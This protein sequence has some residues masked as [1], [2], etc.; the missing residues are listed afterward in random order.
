M[1]APGNLTDAEPTDSEGH[2]KSS[3]DIISRLPV[4]SSLGPSVQAD[5]AKKLVRKTVALGE[6]VFRVGDPPGDF[7]LIESGRVRAVSE[8]TSGD[9]VVLV[10]LGPDEYFGELS[11]LTDA[12]RSV[13]IRAAEETR[14]LVLPGD[15][16]R[17]VAT[18]NP[19]VRQA[20]ACRMSLYNLRLFLRTC[21]VFSTMPARLMNS[22]MDKI[23]FRE[24][25]KGET[26]IREGD[27]GKSFFTIDRGTFEVFRG[28]KLVNALG[29]G[30]SFGEVSLI[31]LLPRSATVKASSDGSLVVV[32]ADLCERIIKEAPEFDERLKRSMQTYAL[33]DETPTAETPGSARPPADPGDDEESVPDIVNPETAKEKEAREAKGARPGPFARFP[34]L[35]QQDETDCAAACLGMVAKYHGK[36]MSLSRLRDIV[37]VTTE[38]AS[39][40]SLAHGA[41]SIGFNARAMRT[42]MAK[43]SSLSLPAI[44]HWNGNHYV[45]LWNIR[46]SKA[47]IGDPAIGRKS[48]SLTEFE[49]SWTGYV[50]ELRAT[51][52]LKEIKPARTSLE[53]FVPLLSEHRLIIFEV[54]LCSFLLDLFGL[55]QPLFTQ[56]VV[57]KVFVHHSRNLLNAMLVGM[58]CVSVLQAFSSALRRY[59]IVYVSSKIDVALITN[60]LRHLMRLPVKYFDVR[61]VGDVIARVDEN[62]SITQTFVGVVP[63]AILDL[64]MAAIYIVMM[65]FYSVKL[66]LIV[67][68]TVIPFA[69]LTLGFTP[70]IRANRREMFAR[71]AASSSFL[72]ENI[73]GIHTVKSLAIETP[74]R[75]KWENLFHRVLSEMRKGAHIDIWQE[76]LARFLSTMTT[77]VLFWYGATLVLGGSLTLGQLFAFNVL[78]GNVM[79]PM[80]GLVGL[81]DQIQALRISLDR[82]NDV[83]DSEAEEDPRRTPI[84]VP[85]IRGEIRFE[86]VTF[87]YGER[88]EKPILNRFNLEIAA[89]STVALV[90]RSGSGKTTLSRMILRFYDPQQGRVFVDGHD[91][92][93]IGLPSLRRQIGVV[94]QDVVLFAGSIRDNISPGSQEIPMT[95]IIEAAQMAGA[96]E[97][98]SAF[99]LGYDTPVGERG[100]TLSGGQRQRISIARAILGDPSILIL[101][102]ATSALDTE[103][104]RAIQRNI[105]NISKGRTTIII[106]HR[107]STVQRADT[108]VVLDQGGV[109]EAGNHKE[110]VARGGL[111]AHL[112]RQQLGS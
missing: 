44:C 19:Q 51:D 95:R 92:R 4:F 75:W 45:V 33:L 82:L 42:S 50:M 10:T 87:S 105:E 48:V 84:I 80:L 64:M 57:D 55:A 37:N 46:G 74:M 16:F 101:D 76:T 14:L 47:I 99:P 35:A 54:F 110:L 97:F 60:F 108:I 40:A 20:F 34:F 66:T 17:S 104:E 61:K 49:N 26:I 9:E 27:D 18:R 30:E 59:L 68:A 70:I 8:T 31:T 32:E 58:A 24:V 13:T 94:P 1:S 91:L 7:F 88:S 107:L 36:R 25:R 52:A 63:T 69:A 28:S 90:G 81:W 78:V 67:L 86:N 77:T 106:A 89:G 56:T 100:V 15:L 53:R 109:A 112:V 39:L 3:L 83:F 65:S 23:Q 71:H 2:A 73:S 22:L 93:T 72:I 96:H 11:I 29:P 21:T 111:Y 12:P 62:S 38:G 103:S 5:I 98:I 6:V 85:R 43:L 41:E 102:E 79:T